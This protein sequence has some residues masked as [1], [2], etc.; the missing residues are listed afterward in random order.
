MNEDDLIEGLLKYVPDGKDFLW[1]RQSKDLTFNYGMGVFFHLIA[2]DGWMGLQWI[3]VP[4]EQRKKGNAKAVI[5]R[6]R[7][8]AKKLNVG[9]WL[10]CNPFNCNGIDFETWS[11]KDLTYDTD[12]SQQEIMVNLVKKMQFKERNIG[13]QMNLYE[14]MGRAIY[15]DYG[16]MPRM[17]VFNCPEHGQD[18]EEVG[19]SRDTWDKRLMDFKDKYY[20]P[21]KVVHP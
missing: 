18:Y 3:Y 13:L 14:V 15:Y 4:E 12:D 17:F 11:L 7:G 20:D 19:L 2:S 1:L 5:N 6:L 9:L 16:A 8:V 21:E 10:V